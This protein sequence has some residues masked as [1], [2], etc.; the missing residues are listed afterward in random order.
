MMRDGTWYAI[1]AVSLLAA[2]G[3]AWGRN[4]LPGGR[5]DQ[6][7]PSEFDSRELAMGIRVEAQH[8]GRHRPDLARQIAMDHLAEIPDYYTRL[9][10]MQRGSRAE[11]Y[12]G[13]HGA[14]DPDTGSPLW[15]LRGV[16]PEDVYSSLGLRYYG[17]GHEA[18][19]EAFAL[20]RAA[21][22]RRDKRIRIYRAIP[23]SLPRGTKINP[24][25]WVAIT[26]A[27]ARDHGRSLP[28]GYKVLSM[29]VP[30]RDLFTN[31]DSIQEW[32]YHPQP[33]VSI[34]QRD[35]EWQRWP[36]KKGSAAKPE[37]M[38]RKR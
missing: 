10:K 34:G 32:G 17:T 20:V 12:H 23:K 30:A 27:Y 25:D 33:F 6:R 7:S 28:G 15:D 16:Y 14:P 3:A 26:R 24:G 38:A 18:D 4:L 21:R 22:G 13:W 1:G 29:A 19:A 35:P 9:L 37:R 8:V 2:S 31:G 36:G 11:D 5:A